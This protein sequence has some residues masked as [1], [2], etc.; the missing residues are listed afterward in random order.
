MRMLTNVIVVLAALCFFA[1]TIAAAAGH[2]A[3][4]GVIHSR[5]FLWSPE[6]WWRGAVGLLLFAITFLLME[7]RRS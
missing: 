2:H 4:Y 5:I 3:L 7:R 6:T 1:G